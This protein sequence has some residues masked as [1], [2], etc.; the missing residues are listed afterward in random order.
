MA[1]SFGEQ[2][3][4]AR[5]ARGVTLRQISDQTHISIRYLEAIEADDYKQL[6]GGIFNRSFVKSYARAVGFDEAEALRL[7][8][9]AAGEAADETP[10]RQHSRIYTDD[11][12]SRSPL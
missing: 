9:S 6:P 12:P 1:A 2:L 5:E 7:Y 4:L 3:R 8:Q 10:T 11:A